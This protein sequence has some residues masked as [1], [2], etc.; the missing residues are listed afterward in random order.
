MNNDYYK[1]PV[2]VFGIVLPMLVIVILLGVALYMNSSVSGEYEIKK[3]KYDQSQLAMRQTM[4]LQGKVKKNEKLLAEWDRMMR[5]ETRGSFLEH[6]K[7]AEK[8]FSGKELTKTS[9]NWL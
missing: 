6:W 2:A 9:H 7:Q 5:S 4:E 8:K 3:K 1:Q